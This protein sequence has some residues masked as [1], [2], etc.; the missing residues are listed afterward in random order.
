MERRE[1]GNERVGQGGLIG[2]AHVEALVEKKEVPK[3]CGRGGGQGGRE[4]EGQVRAGLGEHWHSE[5]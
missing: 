1:D 3:P 2:F 5:A 4:Q